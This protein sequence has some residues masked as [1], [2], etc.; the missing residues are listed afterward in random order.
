VKLKIKNSKLTG[1]SASEHY[2]LRDKVGNGEAVV[3]L[4]LRSTNSKVSLTINY[5]RTIE[6]L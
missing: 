5:Y 2:K 3:N 6:L 4:I 1:S